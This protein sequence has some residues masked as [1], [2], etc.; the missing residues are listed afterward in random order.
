MKNEWVFSVDKQKSGVFTENFP[1]CAE[2]IPQTY[3]EKIPHLFL[4]LLK[5]F[6]ILLHKS[7][8]NCQKSS[9]D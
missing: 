9:H 4:K 1:R 7:N 3:F 5:K 8:V 6:S 2:K